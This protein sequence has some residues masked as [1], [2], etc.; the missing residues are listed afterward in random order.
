[1]EAINPNKVSRLW[2]LIKKESLILG[3]LVLWLK[4]FGYRETSFRVPLCS[5]HTLAFA[6]QTVFTLKLLVLGVLEL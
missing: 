4:S 1:M 5:D 2:D 3:A 6:T